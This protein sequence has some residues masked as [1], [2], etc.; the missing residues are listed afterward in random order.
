[1]I[2]IFVITTD[3]DR[4]VEN[5]LGFNILIILALLYFTFFSN[6]NY[7]NDLNLLQRAISVKSLQ[8][9]YWDSPCLHTLDN[10]RKFIIIIII[11]HR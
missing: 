1:M 8:Y 7:G 9:Q 3:D 2:E 11:R 6:S 4:T 10:L 5:V